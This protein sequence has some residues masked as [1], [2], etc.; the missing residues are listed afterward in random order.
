MKPDDRQ[1]FSSQSARQLPDIPNVHLVP[2]LGE[3]LGNGGGDLFRLV[4][5]GVEQSG[6]A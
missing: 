2:R 3:Q 6:D 5:G 4:F 1:M